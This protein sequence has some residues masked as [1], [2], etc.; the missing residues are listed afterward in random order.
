MEVSNLTDIKRFLDVEECVRF[1]PPDIRE[2]VNAEEIFSETDEK[3]EISVYI[4]IPFCKSPCGFCPFNQYRF[5]EEAFSA[6]IQSLKKEID[7]LKKKI[8]FSDKTITSIWIGGGTPL[9][10][11]AEQLTDLLSYVSEKFDL[12]KTE[13]FTIEGKPVPGMIT[14][15]KLQVL[16]R[17]SVTRISLGIQ[18]THKKYLKLLGR[19]YTFEQAVEIIKKITSYG[20]KLNLDMIYHIPGETEQEIADDV[21]NISALDVE[22]ISWFHY[23]SHPG[24][25]LTKKFSDNNTF[26][27]HD[28]EEF[29]E[30]YCLVRDMME[31]A[32]Y[33]Q[34]T[35]YYYTLDKECRYHVDRWRMPQV[36]VVG[37]GSGA[38]S[39]YNGWIYSNAHNTDLYIDTVNSGKVPVTKGKKMSRSDCISRYAVLGC[40]FFTLDN[41]NFFRLTGENLCSY[42]E[43]KLNILL[44][45]GLVYVENGNI[46]CT[47]KGK[48]FN[49]AIAMCLSDEKYYSFDQ[50]QPLLIRKEGL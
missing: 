34:Y 1:Y 23:I 17:Y 42:F 16:K 40:K 43:E 2:I 41:E 25:P 35:P 37:I 30:K 32:G 47:E 24:T 11:S 9:D 21:R 31:V 4:H 20:L 6:Y 7:L 45:L 33:R 18:S 29:Y 15:E 5:D 38:F 48:A 12:S 3:K 26:I 36:D 50:P 46:G 39:S 14:D 49:N 44:Q 28:N 27:S 13:E 8:S 10:L 22:H 19:N